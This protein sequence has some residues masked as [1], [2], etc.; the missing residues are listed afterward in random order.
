MA[1][2]WRCS[3]TTRSYTGV[4]IVNTFHVVARPDTGV[5]TDASANG[6]R[7]ALHS[8]L[9]TKYRAI[10]GTIDTVESL[11]VRQEVDPNGT[12]IPAESV[13]TIGL[14]GTRSVGDQFLA[15]GLC[16]LATLDSNAAVRGGKGRM[17]MPPAYTSAAASS[18]GTW[19]ATNAYFTTIK[20]FLDELL[21]SHHVGSAGTGWSLDP[22]VYSRTRRQRADPNY[23]FDIVAYRQRT[24]QHFLRS[25]MTAP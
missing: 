6:V 20:T 5:L 4:Q 18:N 9:T 17:F 22:I 15:A 24:I 19:L 25:R 23:Y 12:A 7:D 3:Y 16:C 13:Q 21:Q 2:Q 14:A 8:A 1:L 11:V 10:V